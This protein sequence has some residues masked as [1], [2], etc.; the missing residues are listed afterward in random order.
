[1]GKTLSV[2][3]RRRVAAIVAVVVAV[4]VPVFDGAV[5][6][7]HC[8]CASGGQVMR[9]GVVSC[10]LITWVH[11]L[12]F[13]LWSAAL[14]RSPHERQHVQHRLVR[15][16]VEQRLVWC[17]CCCWRRVRHPL[18]LLVVVVV[19]LAAKRSA[20][21]AFSVCVCV[22]DWIGLCSANRVHPPPRKATAPRQQPSAKQRP[23]LPLAQASRLY[24]V[25]KR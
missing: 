20:G 4:A 6:A 21:G 13:P 22:W 25:L 18:L 19:V 15:K 1:M 11:W 5:D 2:R 16:A 17:C 9:G 10:T 7:P 24:F 3:V 23:A 14:A 8:N 12:V